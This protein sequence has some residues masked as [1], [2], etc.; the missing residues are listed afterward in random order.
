M[1]S[2]RLKERFGDR[3]C[4]HGGVDMQ[5]VLPFGSPEDVAAEVRR[6]L[7]AMAP[8]GGYI[9]AA[10]HNIQADTPPQNIIAMFEAASE[11]GRYPLRSSE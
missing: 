6:V 5:R 11:Y 3:L 4:F 2:R 10:A 9:L 7:D 1:E 8:R